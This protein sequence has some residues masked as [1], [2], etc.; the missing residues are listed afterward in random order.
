MNKTIR[1]LSAKPISAVHI[2]GSKSATHRAFL[3]AALAE[4]ESIVHN[5]LVAE[6]THLTADALRQLGTRIDWSGNAARIVPP[7]KRWTTPDAPIFLGNSG[8]SMRLL[9]AVAACGRGR[10]V[11][12]GTSRLRERPI[13]PVAESL[14]Q[15][16]VTVRWLGEPGYPPIELES[17]GL[18]AGEALIDASK[19]SQFFSALLIA[20]PHA[21]GELRIRPK[22]DV[23]SL[24]YVNLTLSMMEEAGIDF[25]RD[26]D[27]GII[28]P[29]PQRTPGRTF[30]VEGDCSSASYFWAAAA[31][32]GGEVFT[33][34]LNPSSV[35]GD[36][37]LLGMLESMGCLIRWEDDGVRVTGPETLRAID[38]DMNETPDVVP[39]LAVVAAFAHGSSRIRNV[40]H[41][42]VKESDRLMA[43]TSELSKLGVPVTETPD[44][45]EIEGG[46]ARTPHAPIETHD[47]H[48]IAMSMAV[49]GLKIP[50]MEIHGAECVAKSFPEFWTTFDSLGSEA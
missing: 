30:T 31:V 14:E 44:G 3:L 39:T 50:G 1:P 40:A 15:L 17:T 21:D 7:A 22:G 13:G 11:F 34:P 25:K 28:V 48:R 43:M 29:A 24:P 16:G 19:S 49:A 47:D 35:Q 32:T 2:P 4:G 5:P 23:A 42:R 27:S 10:F 45:L 26:G 33:N 12:D 8:T 36:C 37:R 18:R 6:D 46:K 9:L 20:A 41:L 38:I